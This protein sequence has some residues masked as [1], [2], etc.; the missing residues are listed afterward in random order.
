MI[1]ES[2]DEPAVPLEHLPRLRRQ[3]RA[4]LLRRRRRSDDAVDRGRRPPR[5]VADPRAAHPSPLRPRLRRRRAAR[6]LAR[7]RGAD[8]PRR[9]RPDRRRGRLRGRRRCRLGGGP[10]APDPG[11][12]DTA[13]R[14]T[15]G[16]PVAYA[17]AHR[18]DALLS[19]RR[20]CRCHPRP[21]PGQQ[22][23]TRRVQRRRGRRVHRRHAVQELRRRRQSA[24]PQHLRRPARLDHGHA[25]GAAAARPSSTPATPTP[26][27]LPRSGK[28]T[29]SSASG[30]GS[31][32]RAQSRARR[33]ASPPRSCCSAQD[34]DGGTKAWVRWPDG[35][36][37][38][39]PGSKVQPA[40]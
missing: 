5:P 36:D 25:D 32:R 4:G 12:R 2:I 7:D 17:R 34:Y 10:H 26:R 37:D 19:R 15:R 33:S 39:V 13:L 38:I 21:R 30:G 20:R 9:A 6:A 22:R 29:A 18:R 27:R 35:A 23:L 11:R 3:R 40:G 31:T 1:V 14:H 24:R 8:Q 16:A 28:A